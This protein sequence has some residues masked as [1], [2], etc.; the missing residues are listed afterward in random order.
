[1]MKYI[2]FAIVGLVLTAC[3]TDGADSPPVYIEAIPASE[4][5]ELEVGEDLEQY[6]T[7]LYDSNDTSI[8][9]GPVIENVTIPTP[10]RA[11]RYFDSCFRYRNGQ[12]DC[13]NTDSQSSG[14]WRS[15]HGVCR[16]LGYDYSRGGEFRTAQQPLRDSWIIR[17]HPR[18]NGAT[19][20]EA[21]R[22][23]F[24]WVKLDCTRTIYRVE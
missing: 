17:Q 7:D 16:D 21:Y 20:R 5:S 23:A 11:G 8:P 6:I 9:L 18:I 22:G 19:Y 1:M 12:V 15:A 13:S 2:Y 24:I 3:Q 4:I 14:R 10:N